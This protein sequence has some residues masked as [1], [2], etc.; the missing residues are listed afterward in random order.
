MAALVEVV[1]PQQMRA[2]VHLGIELDLE[3]EGIGEVQRAA[4]E[5][6]LDKGV[7]DAVGGEEG[8]R[9]V[10][11]AVIADLEAEPVAGGHC[12]LPQYQRMML[13]L[14]AAAQIYGVGVAIL[15]M[16][17]DR[18]LVEI[19]AGVEVGDIEHGVAGADDVERRVEDVFRN[20][21]G[22]LD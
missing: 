16:Q 12:G 4:L 18:G 5:R 11:I 14:L 6:L 3:A 8:R 1:A 10:E 15:D 2:L 21:H 19:A 20:G 22:F 13:M 17:A 9:P 7:S